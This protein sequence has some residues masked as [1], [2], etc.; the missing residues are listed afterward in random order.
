MA[1]K[2]N[3]KAFNISIVDAIEEEGDYGAKI[4]K[5]K[6]RNDKDAICLTLEPYSLNDTGKIYEDIYLWL[7]RK[8]GKNSKESRFIEITGNPESIEETIG[9]DI[10]VEV[11]FYDTGEKIL[12]NVE[13]VFALVYEDEEGYEEEEE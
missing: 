10:G 6:Y 7:R 9:L 5:V 11:K 4:R 3:K 1:S 13:D 8:A 2:K 12:T